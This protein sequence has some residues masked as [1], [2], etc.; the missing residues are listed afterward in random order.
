LIAD[1][2]PVF[3][4]LPSGKKVDY[5]LT[6]LERGRLQTL[7]VTYDVR[8]KQGFETAASGVRLWLSVCGIY[9]EMRGGES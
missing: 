2:Y 1:R 8:T 7:P 5:F 6:L 9:G 4:V 3:W